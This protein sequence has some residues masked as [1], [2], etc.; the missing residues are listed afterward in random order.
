MNIKQLFLPSLFSIFLSC[1]P[2]PG[3]PSKEQVVESM[4]QKEL[5]KNEEL[6]ET[7]GKIVNEFDFS[8]KAT[9]EQKKD[10]TDGIIPWISLENPSPEL[11]QLINADEVV[12]KEKNINVIFDYPLNN[13]HTYTFTNEKG[14]SRKDLILLISKKYHEIYKEEELTS[15]VKTIPLD[16]RTGLINR[17][18]TK[19]KYGIWGH[20]L[21][22]LDLSGI[23][24]HETGDG[25]INVILIVES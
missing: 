9:K 7:A 3:T 25:K 8:L 17:N 13:P 15:E 20:D 14:F 2:S 21:T 4:Q 5:E 10:W 11:N 22:D 12:I 1:N 18:E 6:Y 23:E 19:G 24:V 16:K